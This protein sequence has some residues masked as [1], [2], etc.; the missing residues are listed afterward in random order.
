MRCVEIV[1]S[2]TGGT[3]K[4][5]DILAK[6]IGYDIEEID[7]SENRNDFA[8]RYINPNDFVLIAMPSFSGRAPQVAID[9]LLEINGNGARCCIIAV[10]G[11]RAYEDTLIEM[12]D[13]AKKVHFK[14]VGAISAVAE[15]SI[16]HQFASERPDEIDEKNL[17]EI[18]KEIISLKDEVTF[19][20]GNRPYKKIG[21]SNIIIPKPNKFCSKCGKCVSSCPVG[22]IDANTFLADSDKCISCM[23]CVSICPREARNV[24]EL[25][26][27]VVAVAIKKECSKRK[28]V[29][30]YK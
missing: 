2:P 26:T 6:E 10:Y 15:H 14:V 28:E 13:A 8:T 11:N 19:V 27:K 4:V 29:E 23:R 5:I 12:S 30:L 18:A 20:P 9:R 7:L 21:K 3:K 16:F 17:K 24:N 22:A 1:F 25:L